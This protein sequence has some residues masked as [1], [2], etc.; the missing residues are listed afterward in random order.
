[1]PHAEWKVQ[2]IICRAVLQGREIECFATYAVPPQDQVIYQRIADDAL[3][4]AIRRRSSVK[5]YFK[6]PIRNPL[7]ATVF[8]ATTVAG[9]SIAFACYLFRY[10][11]FGD[12]QTYSILGGVAGF[13]AIGVA[14][15]GWSVSGWVTHRTARSKLT[16]D[17]VA[18]RYAQAA[19][20]DALAAFNRELKDKRID[21]AT[22]RQME[23]SGKVEE[24]T[25]VQG[26]R[27]LLNYYEFISVGVLKGE[28]DAAIV[29][30]TLRGNLTFI[31]EQSMIYILEVQRDNP[32]TLEHFSALYRH[33]KEP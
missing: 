18:A 11:R 12:P 10:V 32:R 7:F 13:C 3:T 29:E 22:L 28:L 5:R 24:R 4:Y 1:V 6:A 17:V 2:R 33:Y 26:L 30:K 9:L 20:G 27:Y 23:R 14:A 25:A 19:F 21:S 16:M 15:I 31:F 8:V